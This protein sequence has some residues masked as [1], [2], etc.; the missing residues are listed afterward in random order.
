MAYK[1]TV[2]LYVT[3][4]LCNYIH[5]FLLHFLPIGICSLYLSFSLSLSLSL[6]LS[7]PSFLPAACCSRPMPPRKKRRPTAGDDLSAKKSRQDR[8]GAVGPLLPLAYLLIAKQS[9]LHN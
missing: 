5:T 8:Y 9:E 2:Y 3:Y 4:S 1:K 6:C 7:V